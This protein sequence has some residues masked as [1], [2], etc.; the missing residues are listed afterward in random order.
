MKRVIPSNRVIQPTFTNPPTH[1]HTRSSK[2]IELL[3]YS[4]LLFTTLLTLIQNKVFEII[5]LISVF[6]L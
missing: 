4:I 2:S 1:T 3:Y 5:F 6:I